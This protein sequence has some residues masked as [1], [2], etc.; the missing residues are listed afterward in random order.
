MKINSID[1]KEKYGKKIR[2]GQ[3][4]I[5]PRSITTYTDWLDEMSRPIVGQSPQGK[6]FDVEVEM[7]VIGESKTD[8][9][10][11]VSNIIADCLQGTIE[12]D[13][14]DLT[15]EGELTEAEKDFVVKWQYS[16]KLT[17]QAWDKTEDRVTVTTS[18]TTLTFDVEGNVETP[19]VIEITP[20][21]ALGSLNIS[22][23]ARDPVTGEDEDIVISSLTSGQTVTIDGEACTVMAGGENKFADTDMWQFPTLLPGSN[24]LTFTPSS[25][26]VSCAVT[27][28]YKP[29]YI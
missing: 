10:L 26:A 27:I 28:T 12:L 13:D 5:N 11:T 18:S 8:A 3:Q 21:N 29:R 17:F 14:V 23:A 22:G 4:T 1:L 16:L 9:E 25:S 24:T 6:Y 20:D 7:I 15:L 19:C 2:I